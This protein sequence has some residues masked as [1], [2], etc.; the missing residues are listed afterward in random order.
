MV[1]MRWYFGELGEYGMTRLSCELFDV[2]VVWTCGSWRYCDG[3]LIVGGS[4]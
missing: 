3:T 1:V 2:T 4:S